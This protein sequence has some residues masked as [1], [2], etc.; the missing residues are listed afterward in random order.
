MSVLFHFTVSV[1]WIT[2]HAAIHEKVKYHELIGVHQSHVRNRRS[3]DQDFG[4]LV[5]EFN[6]QAFNRSFNCSLTPR[7]NF[8]SANFTL[9]VYGADGVPREQTFRRDHIYVGT[10]NGDTDSEIRGTFKEGIFSGSLSYQGQVYGIEN[11]KFHIPTNLEDKEQMIVYRASDVIW[12]EGQQ[13][14]GNGPSFCGNIHTKLNISMSGDGDIVVDEIVKDRAARYRREATPSW[15]TCKIITVADYK[16][17]KGMGRSDIYDTAL[18]MAGVM[19]RVDAIYRKTSFNLD[20]SVSGFGLEI[21]KMVI[22]EAAT[23]GFNQAKT[24]WEPLTLLQYFSRNLEYKTYCAAHLFTHQAFSGNILGLAYIA[25]S[26]EGAVGGICS[27]VVR[28]DNVM[29]SL[30]TAWSST[31]NQNGDTVLLKQAD[32]VTAHGH[33]WGAEHDPESGDCSPSTVYSKGKYLMYPYS[34]SGYDP[35]NYLFSPCSRDFIS[36]VLKIKG[37]TCFTAKSYDENQVCGNGRI[38]TGEEC[39]AGFIGRF[40]LDKCCDSNCRLINSA[41]CSPLNHECCSNCSMSPAGTTCRSY[42]GI[43]CL[44]SAVCNG[45]T[46]ECPAPNYRAE[47][48]PCLDKGLCRSGVCVPFCESRNLTACACENLANS[49]Q[50]C[51]RNNS[52]SPCVPFDGKSPLPDGRPCVGGYCQGNVCKPSTVSTIQR[53]FQFFEDLSIDNVVKFFRSNLVGCVIVFS[54]LLWVPASTVVWCHDRKHLKKSQKIENIELRQNRSLLHDEDGRLVTKTK[55]T[56]SVG[57]TSPRF[58]HRQADTSTSEV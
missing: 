45:Y 3:A 30:N 18:Y 26:R 25:P 44:E 7:L 49:C 12:P 1:L 39:D 22:Y 31:K 41:T 52:S 8:F 51:C 29:S 21:A 35:N 34:V 15:N 11:A 53:L 38:D 57:T 14:N 48:S 4:E 43:N 27:P 56:P 24:D 42:T 28:M 2:A 47:N 46:L 40:N 32:L 37:S 9:T 36:R 16:F 13:K 19:D 10:C 58:R 6:F 17:F 54:L 23:S 55:T 5:K 50:R 20:S 33:N